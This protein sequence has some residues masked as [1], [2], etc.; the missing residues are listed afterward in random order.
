MTEVHTEPLAPTALSG[1]GD[2]LDLA[3]D[4]RIVVSVIA[5]WQDGG[6]RLL[7][8]TVLV[9]LGE[10]DDAGWRAWRERE[11][12]GIVGPYTRSPTGSLLAS[13]GER[14]LM[15]RETVTPDVAHGWLDGA[16][17]ANATPTVGVIPSLAV[18][19]VL[20]DGLARVLP[21]VDSAAS[22]LIAGV[23]RPVTGLLWRPPKRLR[24]EPLTLP[25]HV[26]LV[27]GTYLSWPSMDVCGIH[28]SPSYVEPALH[29]REGLLVG[30][31]E[32]GAWLAQL[33]GAPDPVVTVTIGHDPGRLPLRDLE[34]Q[35]NQYD[36]DNLLLRSDRIRLSDLD[37]SGV[38]GDRATLTVPSVGAKLKHEVVLSDS[39]GRQIDRV[40][41]YGFFEVVEAEISV[42]PGTEPTVVRTGEAL[43]RPTL[44][45]R[46]ALG[47]RAAAE[48]AEVAADGARRRLLFG[49]EGRAEL[50]AL[51]ADARGEL[52]IVDPFFGQ[53]DEDWDLL[54]DLH[55]NVRVC[56]SKVGS[57]PSPI[58]AG[59]AA[60]IRSNKQSAGLH[61][62]IYVWDGGGLAVG[63]SP[64]TLRR[65][66]IWVGRLTAAEAAVHRER[67]DMFWSSPH[68]ADLP[69]LSDLL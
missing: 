32:R 16:S 66:S 47:V 7:H 27:D 36:D 8:G 61:D 25:A 20:P 6:W 24:D 4:E 43:Q 52:L 13:D 29:T 21:S 3:D 30:R 39:E 33:K 10:C 67:F 60:R 35:H 14:F 28:L 34:I 42:G 69:A 22:S 54:A 51:L 2:L 48:L 41:P 62:R 18:D 15:A 53:L 23:G 63:G 45:E 57:N 1:G 26:E 56:T 17:T 11:E 58:P 38:D 5:D 44:I 55:V 65:A 19:L 46:R 59:V 37:L 12:D 40:G 64:S 68:F 9:V 31:M 50:R 49:D